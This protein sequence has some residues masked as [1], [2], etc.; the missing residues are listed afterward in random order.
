MI[1]IKNLQIKYGDEV[2]LK[3]VDL[4]VEKNKTCAII[5][6]SGCGK[7]T[8]IYAIAG[9]IKADKGIIKID[10]KKLID[11]RENTGVILQNYGLL[12][13]KNVF[14]NV[15]LGLKIRNNEE[16][17][18]RNKTKKILKELNIYN[19]KEKYPSE[20]SGGQKQRVAI[21]RSLALKVDL[22]LLDEPSSSLDALSKEKLQDLILKI[23]KKNPL[24]FVIVTHNIEEAVFLGQKIVIMGRGKIKHVIDNPYF[25]DTNLR[26]KLEFYKVCMEVRKWMDVGVGNEI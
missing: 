25:G 13:W 21:G 5:G 7:T 2:A 16:R 4:E 20:L 3:S 15:A 8:L 11:I 23:Y 1:D 24:T 18:I 6:P 9:L 19:C 26:N 10:E 14:E 22:L 17:I 12:P